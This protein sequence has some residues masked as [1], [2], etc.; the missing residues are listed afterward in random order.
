MHSRPPGAS[1]VAVNACRWLLAATFV[2][3]GAVKLID[4]IGTQYKIEEYA[5]S[6]GMPGL[7]PEIVTLA[8]AVGLA[9]VEFDLGVCLLFGIH[10][11][12]VPRFALL[13]LLAMLLLT[14]HA[15]ATG[16]MEHCGCFGDA[17]PLT[18]WQTVAKNAMLT[19]AAIL[20]V[21]RSTLITRLMLKRNQWMV[22][23]HTKV[24]ALAFACVSLYGL[25]VIDFR[26]YHIGADLLAKMGLKPQENGTHEPGQI[27][28]I[29]DFSM[30]RIEDGADITY[31]FLAGDTY[32]F[33]LLAPRLDTADEGVMDR[34]A[35][36]HDYARLQ[37]YPFYC[38]T[39]S[40]DSAIRRWTEA[41]GADYPFCR[42][43]G[44]VLRTMV[45]SN[46]GL[47]LLKGSM[48]E[49]KWASTG[50][51]TAEQLS[52]P[53][54]ELAGLAPRARWKWAILCYLLPL[55]AIWLADRLGLGM[56]LRKVYKHHKRLIHFNKRT[57]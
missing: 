53:M 2:L 57:V 45:R 12:R 50:L 23:L 20:V 11:K 5:I 36:I 44:T 46:P 52:A 35:A 26:P 34:I 21:W 29:T 39:S 56:K 7:L 43:D 31:D 19:A 1:L 38:L 16:T 25:P 13:F 55:L 9:L 28:E 10:R 22:T 40:P 37:G 54:E 27:P 33:L 49:G 30:M 14:I 8:I 4:P 41:T 15:A 6:L 3:S 18:P 51:P 47:M 32:K 24:F 42:T 17:W 48:V